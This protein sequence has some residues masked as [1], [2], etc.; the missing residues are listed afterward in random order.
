[1]EI[2]KD[3]QRQFGKSAGSYVTSSI[4]KD[5]KD[6]LK[7][8]EM[9]GVT[10][11]ERLLDVATGGGHTANAFAHSVKEVTAFDLTQEMLDA[12]EIFITGNGHQNVTFVKGDA[13]MLPFSDE[14]FDIVTCRIAPHHFPDVKS[15]IDEAHRVLLSNGQFLLDDN[16]VPED[17]EFDLFYNTIEKIRDYS[18]FRAWKKTEWIQMLEG[19]GFEIFEMHRFEKT[20][21]YEPWCNRMKLSVSEKDKLTQ[22]ILDSSP[23]VKEKFKIVIEDEKIVSFQGEAIVLKAVKR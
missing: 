20:F 14:S 9:A 5:G 16:V 11:E 21:H 18:H 23:I 19:S 1:M 22:Y 4:H 13:E 12:A 7:L 3:V 17:D 2:K 10:G 15:F 6:L 8:V